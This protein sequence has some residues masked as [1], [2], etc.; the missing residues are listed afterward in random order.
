MKFQ[1]DQRIDNNYGFTLGLRYAL[2]DSTDTYANY[3]YLVRD[4]R[5]SINDLE[6]HVVFVGIRKFF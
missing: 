4:S 1:P 3:S 5:P 2:T 6:D